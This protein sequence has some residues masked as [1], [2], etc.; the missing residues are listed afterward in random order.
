MEYRILSSQTG[1]GL[2]RLVQDLLDLNVGWVPF[3]DPFIN[4]ADT[5]YT[6]YNQAMIREKP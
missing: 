5:P 4:P 1:G 2:A 3:G 6:V